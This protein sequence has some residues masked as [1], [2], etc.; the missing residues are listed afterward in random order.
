MVV[1]VSGYCWCYLL[2]VVDG[3]GRQREVDGGGCSCWSRAPL[4]VIKWSLWV[5]VVDGFQGCSLVIEVN[6]D[7]WQT[8]GMVIG[9][10]EC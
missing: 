5:V 1:F 6:S 4:P 3:V 9:S 7:V 10:G 2:V 8:V